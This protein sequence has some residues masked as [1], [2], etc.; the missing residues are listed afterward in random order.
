MADCGVC[1][2][3]GDFDGPIEM[4]ECNEVKARKD[5]KCTECRRVIPKGSL[6]E[7]TSGLFDGDFFTEHTC[8]DCA[9]IRAAFNCGD[10]VAIGELWE[11]MVYAF[12][13]LTTGCFTRLKTAS[14]KAYLM[15]R[16]R[17]WKGL[18]QPPHAQ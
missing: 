12:P 6:Y 15:E 13:Q 9:D 5:H 14:G 17:K 1:I 3:G 11:S 7:R 2:G 10:G 8:M 18:E 16:W 4:F